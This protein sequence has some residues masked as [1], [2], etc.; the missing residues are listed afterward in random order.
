MKLEA[1]IRVLHFVCLLV[2]VLHPLPRHHHNT[3]KIKQKTSTKEQG[4]RKTTVTT[5]KDN[6]KSHAK[7]QTTKIRNN[8]HK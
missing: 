7:Y 4:A 6:S 5:H 1:K 3:N 8:P 2:L